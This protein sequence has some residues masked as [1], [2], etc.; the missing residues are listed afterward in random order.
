MVQQVLKSKLNGQNKIQAINNYVMSVLSRTEGVIEW[1]WIQSEVEELDRKTRKTL[2][3]YK[4]LHQRTDTHRLYLPRQKGGRGLKEVKAT[5][6]EE[7]QGL[8]EY[9]WQKKDSEALL[10]AVWDAKGTVMPPDTTKVWR[11]R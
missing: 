4:G 9:L 7:K 3:M 10:K 8:E 6:R 11:D 5:I 1:M 2:N